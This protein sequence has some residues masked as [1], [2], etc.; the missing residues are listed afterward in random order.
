VT[1]LLSLQ[2]APSLFSDT[3]Y[4]DKL[5]QY[6]SLLIIYTIDTGSIP[7]VKRPERGAD[8]KQRVELYFYCHFG[9]SWPVPG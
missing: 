2:S 1:M 8:V 6:A 5:L 7:G 3:S 9:P 4:V